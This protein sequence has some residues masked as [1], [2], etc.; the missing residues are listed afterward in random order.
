MGIVVS[1]GLCFATV[2]LLFN[3]FQQLGLT[4]RIWLCCHYYCYYH[5]NE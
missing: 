4:T 3:T 5:F 2:G 1:Y